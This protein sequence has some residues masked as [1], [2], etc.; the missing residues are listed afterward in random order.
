M[1]FEELQKN[2]DDVKNIFTFYRRKID[3]LIIKENVEIKEKNIEHSIEEYKRYFD[4]YEN[5]WLRYQDQPVLNDLRNEIESINFLFS[6]IK[7]LLFNLKNLSSYLNEVI[8]TF[9]VEKE[10]GGKIKKIKEIE[11]QIRKNVL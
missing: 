5:N 11:K 9:D 10:L 1:L 4:G 2:I 6:D 8:K 7:N 3:E